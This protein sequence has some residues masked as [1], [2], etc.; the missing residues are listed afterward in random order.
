MLARLAADDACP[1]CGATLAHTLNDERLARADPAWLRTVRRGL[2][3]A[4]AG[5]IA[6]FAVGNGLGA[7]ILATARAE[8][9]PFADAL[10]SVIAWGTEIAVTL[11]MLVAALGAWWFTTPEPGGR[12]TERRVGILAT[13]PALA[14]SWMT[15]G[16]VDERTP[17][18][19]TE[20]EL[21]ATL[22]MAAEQVRALLG[23]PAWLGLQLLEVVL[24]AILAVAWW[25]IL[26]HAAR[27]LDRAADPRQASWM[28]SC[29]TA[30]VVA[31]VVSYGLVL[32]VVFATGLL[33]ESPTAWS[34][35][36]LFGLGGAI[37]AVLV[38]LGD[39]VACVIFG[40]GL[41]RRL[42]AALDRPS[43]A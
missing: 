43:P 20:E 4:I 22:A 21:D 10:W 2:R 12:L 32:T 11:T 19:G 25:C 39:S 29:A 5:T 24:G 23:D 6:S 15:G 1:T 37:L 36:L 26:R 9:D 38:S 3:W 14:L 16:P 42:G 41:D 35:L 34:P 28:R 8:D 40:F 27:L 33:D 13:T 7:G 30:A 17:P 18:A 31:S